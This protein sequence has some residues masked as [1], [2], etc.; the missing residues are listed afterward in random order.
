MNAE[1]SIYDSYVPRDSNSR[2]H[3]ANAYSD[4]TCSMY[5]TLKTG[6]L[7]LLLRERN[8]FEQLGGWEIRRIRRTN[9]EGSNGKLVK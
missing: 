1:T 3:L 7:A 4:S 5:T 8:D 9:D 6:F 2:Y